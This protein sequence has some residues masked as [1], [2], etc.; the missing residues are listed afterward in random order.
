MAIRKSTNVKRIPAF[1][2]KDPTDTDAGW[3]VAGVT[4]NAGLGT[5]LGTHEQIAINYEQYYVDLQSKTKGA[6]VMDQLQVSEGLSI[7]CFQRNFDVDVNS[8][9]YGSSSTDVTD[10]TEPLFTR[11]A[12]YHG[13]LASGSG[14]KL[15]VV[16]RDVDNHPG[17]L[18][19]N[20]AARVIEGPKYDV[21]E[22]YG[23]M[24]RFEGL[25]DS[26]NRFFQD[27]MLQDFS[28]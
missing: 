8:I 23:K 15:L 19:Y 5:M 6:R 17:Y 13:G 11:T 27:G 10:S 4:P 14:F 12:F 28:V 24:I 22:D 3:S 18:L 25:L 20:V 16:P 21:K 26:T 2:F 9:L 1:L 7:V